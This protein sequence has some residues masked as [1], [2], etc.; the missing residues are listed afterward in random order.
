[1]SS[2]KAAIFEWLLRLN[3]LSRELDTSSLWTSR[4]TVELYKRTNQKERERER[5]R[6]RGFKKSKNRPKSDDCVARFTLVLF[7][8][9]VL[10][11]IW[12]NWTHKAHGT[13]VEQPLNFIQKSERER[14]KLSPNTWIDTN[15]WIFG[16][17]AS[18]RNQKHNIRALM[19]FVLVSNSSRSILFTNSTGV[20]RTTKPCPK[21]EGQFEWLLF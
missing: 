2:Q 3:M 4:A 7:S 13:D 21:W 11:L 17:G 18:I 9:S 6:E 16:W 19:T 14:E 12:H 8:L 5:E 1:M 20:W 10:L 15:S